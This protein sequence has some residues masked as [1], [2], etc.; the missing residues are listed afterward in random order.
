MSHN[1]NGENRQTKYYNY[2]VI[3]YDKKN[4]TFN[5]SYGYNVLRGMADK[6]RQSMYEAEQ[7][8]LQNEAFESDVYN[9][10]TTIMEETQKQV[11]NDELRY[12]INQVVW[13]ST[14]Q[15]LKDKMHNE[16]DFTKK[17]Q[18]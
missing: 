8:D 6:M 3:P 12:Y 11:K 10:L 1:W 18:K 4:K 17:I 7:S 13:F 16:P 15:T 14:K 2:D 9:R 5:N